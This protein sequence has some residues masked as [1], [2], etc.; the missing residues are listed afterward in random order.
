[1]LFSYYQ[2]GESFIKQGTN[3]KDRK[4][5]IDKIEFTYNVDTPLEKSS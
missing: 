5:K 2:N 4:K 3:P 1:M